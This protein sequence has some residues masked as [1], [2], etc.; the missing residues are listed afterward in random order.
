[1]GKTRANLKVVTLL[2]GLVCLSTMANGL[3]FYA[4]KNKWYCFK[5]SLASNYTLE[6]EVIVHDQE[7][8][9]MLVEANDAMIARG[10][11]ANQGVRLALTDS[12]NKQ[13]FFGDVHPNVQYEYEAEDAGEYK[14]CVQLTEM[15]FDQ[16]H[17]KIKTSVKFS[18]EFHRSK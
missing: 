5:D 18:S 2:T 10:K 4:E 14:L 16:G 3:H 7:V 12:K 11:P 8:L 17:D 1:M 13:L 6:M 9:E 15:S